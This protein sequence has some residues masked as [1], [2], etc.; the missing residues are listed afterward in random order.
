[1]SGSHVLA[2]ILASIAEFAIGAIWYMP[3]F[4]KQWGEIFEFQKMDKKAQQEMQAKMGPFYGLQLLVTIITTVV[5][6]KVMI[7]LPEMSPYML[8]SM[9]W[10]GFVVPT[11]VSGVIFGGTPPQWIIRKIAIQAGGAL[12]CLLVAAAILSFFQ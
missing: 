1:M 11:Q 12:A 10:I 9:M 4:G 2:V 7:L 3:L 6:S 5:L 8:A